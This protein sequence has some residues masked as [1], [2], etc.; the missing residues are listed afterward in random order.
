MVTHVPGI[1]QLLPKSL[2]PSGF[3]EPTFSLNTVMVFFLGNLRQHNKG[4]E[5]NHLRLLI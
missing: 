3:P 2:G 1:Q 5:E 4:L